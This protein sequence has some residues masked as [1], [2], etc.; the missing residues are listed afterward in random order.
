M[1]LMEQ[2]EQDKFVY[3]FEG[4][5]NTLICSYSRYQEFSEAC[6]ELKTT[7]DFDVKA[8][9]FVP[10]NKIYIADSEGFVVDYVI[11]D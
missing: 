6:L 1:W 3:T 10:H 11:E 2:V 7:K 9:D 4:I 5:R 8:F